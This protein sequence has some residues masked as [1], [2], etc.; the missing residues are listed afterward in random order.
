MNWGLKT[1]VRLGFLVWKLI[2]LTLVNNVYL[3]TIGDENLKKSCRNLT[4]K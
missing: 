4:H 2:F 1:I 3:D